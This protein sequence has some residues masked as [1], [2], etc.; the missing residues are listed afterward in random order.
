MRDL[1]TF[2]G[3]L[4]TI[5]ATGRLGKGLSNGLTQFLDSGRCCFDGADNFAGS[6]T[7]LVEE[8][9]SLNALVKTCYLA[10]LLH[11]SDF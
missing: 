3:D 1:L 11:R 10:T 4:V 8:D 2:T 9:V 5:V 7:M 6:V